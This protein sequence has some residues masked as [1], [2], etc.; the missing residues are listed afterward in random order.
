MRLI[1]FGCLVSM[2]ALVLGGCNTTST[3][4]TVDKRQQVLAMK[5]E[6][7]SDLYELKPHT[8]SMIAEAPGCGVFSNATSILSL[9][10]SAAAMA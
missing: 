5:N 2:L 1:R 4:P 8:K 6:T 7:F 10:V 9:P 3:K